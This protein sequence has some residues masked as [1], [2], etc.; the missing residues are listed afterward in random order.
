VRF[1][2]VKA[3]T[4][5]VAVTGL[6]ASVGVPATTASAAAS[7]SPIK[8][9]LIT[10]Q[11]GIAAAEFQDSPQGFLAR[12]K[13]QNAEGGVNGHPIVP[14]VLNDQGSTTTVA[15]ATQQAISDGAI[16]IVNATPFF[17]AAYKYPQQAGIPVTGGAFDGPEWGQQP[18][19]NMFASDGTATSAAVPVNTAIGNFFKAH[20]GTVAGTYGYGVSPTSAHSAI[21]SAKS[22]KLAGLKVGVLDTS[23]PFG[24]VD[25]TTEA[26]TAKSNHVNALWGSMDNNSNFALVAALKQAGVKPKVAVFPTGYQP[27]IINTPAWQAVQGVYFESNFRPTA[28]PNAGTVQF[29]S[30]LQKYAG[31][32]PKDFP[33]FNIY[34]AWLGADLM[35]KGLQLAGKNPTSAS[36]ITALRTV[37]AY[38]GNGLLPVPIN[39]ATG[40]GKAS[41]IACGW[42]MQAQKNG[43]VASSTQPICGKNLAGTTSLSS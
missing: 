30:A 37:K 10:S 5:A 33:T 6:A 11:T 42:Y 31:R 39:Y 22:A 20:G 15:T 24:G 16:G 14:I 12:I 8:I 28:V 29:A 25:F 2:L 35:I 21:G 9:A 23:V 1:K 32:A 34:E 17:F 4:A 40:F 18:N 13:L 3:A 19:T 27:D 38:T 41:P 36:V 26:L 7:G 43:F